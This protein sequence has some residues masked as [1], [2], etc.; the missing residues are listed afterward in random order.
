MD[1]VGKSGQGAKK[2]HSMRKIVIL[3]RQTEL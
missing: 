3:L 1:K 2:C